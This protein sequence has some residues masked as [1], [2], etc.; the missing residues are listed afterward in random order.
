MESCLAAARGDQSLELAAALSFFWMKRG[1]FREGQQWLERAL[2]ASNNA[3]PALRAK[4]LMGLGTMTF[5]QGDF[6]RTRAL[7][8]ESATLGRTAGDLFVVAFSLGI[9]ALAALELGDITECATT[10]R[11]RAGSGAAS[12]APWTQGPSLTCLAYQALY[13]GD[14]DRAGQ[15]HEEVL[16]L[17]A[18]RE[19]SG[20]WGSRCSTSGCFEPFSTATRRPERY[21][22]KASFSTRNSETGAASPGAW[23][24]LREPRPPKATLSARRGCGEPWRLCSRAWARLFKP[25]T[26]NGLAIV[27]SPP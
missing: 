24:F 13:E 27:H 12:G 20:A 16:V 2:S 7:L 17:F 15:L 3:S 25:P 5:F 22:P 9:S 8:E 6:A 21:A 23:E 10:R 19:R 18:S 1:Y 26:T 4:A 11:R 14:L